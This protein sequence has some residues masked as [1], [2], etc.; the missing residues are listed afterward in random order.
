MVR[1]SSQ[2][3][4]R[5]VRCSGAQQSPRRTAGVLDRG[6]RRSVV[7]ERSSSRREGP[8]LHRRDGL[9]RRRLDALMHCVGGAGEPCC[10]VPSPLQRVVGG[11]AGQR[12]AE[13]ELVVDVASQAQA[14]HEGVRRLV[15]AIPGQQQPGVVDQRL[16]ET[17]V[18]A[19]TA[20]Q[21][22]RLRE[23]LVRRR[24]DVRAPC[25]TSPAPPAR[26]PRRRDRRLPGR[27]ARAWAAST[28]ARFHSSARSHAPACAKRASA[29]RIGSLVW[30]AAATAA[31][32]MLAASGAA[33]STARRPRATNGGG[34]DGWLP[35]SRAACRATARGASRR[36]RSDP[37]RAPTDRPNSIALAA[38]SER[39]WRLGGEGQGEPDP[40]PR[41]RGRPTATPGRTQSPSA[42]PRRRHRHAGAARTPTRMLPRSWASRSSQWRR[43]ER[44]ACSAAC[45][46]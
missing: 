31:S 7:A 8:L 36:R 22:E 40:E 14:L 29:R 35:A 37:G 21:L 23:V 33:T 41:R 3:C 28:P 38:S 5:E 6:A 26:S 20:A 19:L 44:A 13:V 15:V 16:D 30:L 27:G 39:H 10:V 43:S 45:S 25:R 2:L 1:A 34:L 9:P 11:Q 12:L 46:Q 17:A 18:V 24:R 42:T 32:Q 4:C